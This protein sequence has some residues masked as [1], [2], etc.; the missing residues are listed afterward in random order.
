MNLPISLKK[1]Y[2]LCAFWISL[3][4][5]TK[6]LHDVILHASVAFSFQKWFNTRAVLCEVLCLMCEAQNL[7]Y[8]VLTTPRQNYVT[9]SISQHNTLSNVSTLL[10]R[11]PLKNQIQTENISLQQTKLVINCTFKQCCGSGMIYSG[12]G[13]CYDI[14]EFRT[15]PGNYFF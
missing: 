10:S 4:L 3:T 8:Q 9:C 11:L 1:L 2:I 6:K 7:Q 13:S 15:Q 5:G 14:L 12:P